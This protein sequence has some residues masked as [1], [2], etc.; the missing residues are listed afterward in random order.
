MYKII[1]THTYLGLHTLNPGI[2]GAPRGTL[3]LLWRTLVGMKS[4]KGMEGDTTASEG[5]GPSSGCSCAAASASASS[6][7]A[8]M[9]LHSDDKVSILNC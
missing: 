1:M 9:R 2:Q 5:G 8:S 3:R 4:L 7:T 6:R